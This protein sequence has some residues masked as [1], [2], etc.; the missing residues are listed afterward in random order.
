M[1]NGVVICLGICMRTLI[2]HMSNSISYPREAVRFFSCAR[3]K[4]SNSCWAFVVGKL[5]FGLTLLIDCLFSGNLLSSM[6][7]FKSLVQDA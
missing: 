5:M 3:C 7:H 2:F 4:G 6:M 1:K